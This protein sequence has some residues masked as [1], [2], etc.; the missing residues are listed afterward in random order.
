MTEAL[1]RMRHLLVYAIILVIPLVFWPWVRESYH[2]VKES[3]LLVIGLPALVLWLIEGTPGLAHLPAWYRWAVPAFLAW[4]CIR[5]PGHTD[6]VSGVMQAGEWALAFAAA[7]ACLGLGGAARKRAL[8]ALAAGTALVSLVGFAQLGFGWQFLVP[9]KVDPRSVTFTE[10][11]VFSTFGNPIFFAGYLVL[12]IP[13]TAAGFAL[14]VSGGA[15]RPLR[16]ALFWGGALLLE[17]AALFLASSRSAFI[18]A[19][20]GMG[21][22]FL[23]IRELRKWA[24]AAA[25]TAVAAFLVAWVME[26]ALVR[27]M[28]VLGDPGRI[29]MWRTA[30]RMIADAPLL[31]AGSGQFAAVYPCTQLR[32]AAPDDAGYGVNAFHAHN[33][34][35]EAAAEW[36]I[37]GALLF[38]AVLLGPL[39]FPP[40]GVMGWGARAGIVGIAVQALFNFPFRVSPT[41]CFTWLLP[42]VFLLPED[43]KPRGDARPVHL[44]WLAAAL[45]AAV[46]LRPMVRSSYIQWALAYQDAHLYARSAELFGAAERLMRDDASSRAV[47]LMGKMRFETGDLAAAQAAFERDLAMFPCYPES[48]GNLGVVYGVRAMQG[49]KGALAKAQELVG[50]AVTLRPGGREAAGDYNSLGNLRIIAG[51]DRGALEAYTQALRWDEGL[52]EAAYNASRLLARKGKRAEAARVVIRCLELNPGNAELAAFAAQLGARP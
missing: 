41:S 2:L 8:V 52:V 26:P 49:E 40:A 34:Y 30:G 42:A 17:A 12:V 9:Y 25:G 51:D 44:G 5:V 10:E 16:R 47:F 7:A 45:A 3:G 19:A 39:L 14:A 50:K 48:Y 33:E 15:A 13:L 46:L 1:R 32:V 4:I 36:G 28:M 43:E 11:R 23:A 20:A 24:W 21:V 38:L 6:P 18:G 31:G 27:H 29:L 37:P 35:L 22:M